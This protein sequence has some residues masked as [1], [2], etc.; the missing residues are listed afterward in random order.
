MFEDEKYLRDVH[1]FRDRSD[2]A[3]IEIQSLE[4]VEIA[5]WRVISGTHEYDRNRILQNDDLLYLPIRWIGCVGVLVSKADGRVMVLGSGVQL[6][7]HVWAYYRGFA[8]GETSTERLNDL[9]IVRIADE[10]KTEDVLR[11]FLTFHYIVHVVRPGFRQL[12][13]RITDVDLYFAKGKFKEAEE[14]GWFDFRVEAPTRVD[15]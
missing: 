12:P 1:G 3:W 10:R 15:A 8:D 4:Q 5:V 14:Q 9:V 13:L 2:S 11:C 6:S 7:A